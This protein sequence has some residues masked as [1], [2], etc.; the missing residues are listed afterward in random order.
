MLK[1]ELMGALA[2]A[3]LWVNTLLIAADAG[4]QLAA[5]LALRSRLADL[6][7]GRVVHGDGPGGA[8]ASRR[9]EQVGRA[10]ADGRSI[11]FHDRTAL[12]EIHGGVIA[13]DAGGELAVKASGDAE[14]WLD[15]DAITRAAACASD[16]VFDAAYED[17]RKARGYVRTM[18]AAIGSGESVLVSRDGRFLAT[19]DPRAFLGRKAVLAVAFIAGEIALAAAFTLI[20]LWPPVFGPVSTVGGLLCLG[21]FLAV[22]PAG[23]ALRDAILVPSRAA[24]P[25]R[26]TRAAAA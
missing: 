15:R 1:P 6:V 17:A 4:K 3:I 19:I 16:Q 23:T 9:I 26:W 18:S 8:L 5:L 2:L 11:L 20:A 14:V 24:V 12:G 22:Q 10:C 7:H 25:V 21:F 13:L